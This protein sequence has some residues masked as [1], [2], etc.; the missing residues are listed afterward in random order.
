MKSSVAKK[1]IPVA[2]T[3]G[4]NHHVKECL[5]DKSSDS[6]TLHVRTKILK[7]KE[8]AE[9]IANGIMD[10]AIS[11]KN[12]KNNVFL[13]SLTV[14]NVRLNVKGKNLSSL[15]K[16]KRDEEKIYFVNNTNINVSMLNN[17]GLR[18]NESGTH[19]LIIIFVLVWSNEGIGIYVDTVGTKKRWF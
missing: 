8:S 11:I 15:L 17:S 3:K 19:I 4:M 9:H 16:W 7:N 1:S 6:I 10:P 13:S 12:E 18:L 5:E 14:Q 2:T